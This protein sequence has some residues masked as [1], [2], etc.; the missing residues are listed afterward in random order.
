MEME[1]A[2]ARVKRSLGQGRWQL[3]VNGQA[4]PLPARF[5][6]G[7]TRDSGAG[8][9]CNDV[10]EKKEN[11]GKERNE[12]CTRIHADVVRRARK[13]RV[14]NATPYTGL[15]VVSAIPFPPYEKYYPTRE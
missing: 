14:L 8:R 1:G 10:K 13:A 5:S 6:I 2:C 15:E 3:G 11:E 12:K 7:R 9:A 4:A